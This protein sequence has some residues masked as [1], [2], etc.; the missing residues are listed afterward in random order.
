MGSICFQEQR[1]FSREKYNTRV[2]L[3]VSDD[4]ILSTENAIGRQA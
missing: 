1:I 3:T 2:I 4:Y